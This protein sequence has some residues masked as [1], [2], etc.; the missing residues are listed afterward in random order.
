MGCYD[1]RLNIVLEHFFIPYREC[2]PVGSY[3]DPNPYPNTIQ[4]ASLNQYF[5]TDLYNPEVLELIQQV[6]TRQ[7]YCD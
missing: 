2:K 1:E 3:T 5:T 6:S 7:P 4:N